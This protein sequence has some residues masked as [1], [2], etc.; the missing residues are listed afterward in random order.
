MLTLYINGI[1]AELGQSVAL[2]LTKTFENLSNPTDY[3]SEY[4]KTIELPI[5]ATNNKIFKHFYMADSMVTDQT[6]DPRKK[7]P[8]K[9]LWNSEVVMSGDAKLENANT[10][11][12]DNKYEITLY[13]TFGM[14]MNELSQ[15][16]F[17]PYEDVDEKYVI[18]TPFN[19]D[20]LTVD[21]FLVKESFEQEEH[22]MDGEDVLDYIGFIPTYQG[23]YTDFQS[24]KVRMMDIESS[25][26]VTELSKERDEHY[27]REFRS[28]YQQP[29]IWVNKMWNMLQNKCAE[30]TDYN[31]VLHPSWFNMSNPYW[32][33]L[34][35][36]CPS[37]YNGDDNYIEYSATI[38]SGNT[39][40]RKQITTKNG[41]IQHSRMQV[42]PQ[43][44]S[45]D[46]VTYDQ[47][48][49]VFNPT[50][51]IG[52]SAITAKMYMVIGC[53]DNSVQ[54]NLH[55]HYCRIK[56]GNPVYVKYIAVD[57]ETNQP[58]D[59][60]SYTY[61]FYSGNH[62]GFTN[63]DESVDVG[64]TNRDNPDSPSMVGVRKLD[65]WWW[66]RNLDLTL[67]VLTNKPYRLEVEVY[68]NI[69]DTPFEKA[70]SNIV[71]QWDIL[72]SDVWTNGFEFGTLMKYGSVSSIEH[73]R[74]YS[75]ISMYRIFPKDMTLL[76]VL[77]NYS[78]MFGLL[79]DV[80]DDNKTITVKTRNA[81][82]QNKVI[83]DWTD[84]V[85]K[86][87]D[88]KMNPITF[89]TKY[90]YFNVEDGDCTRLKQYQDK[91]KYGYGSKKIDTEYDFNAE[92]KDLFSGI[93]PSIVSQK[94]QDSF[95]INTEHPDSANFMGYN[96]KVYPNE[97]YVDNDDNGDN[98]GMSGAFYFRRG[99]FA[100]DGRIS[101]T[102]NN[103]NSVVRIT[104]D[105]KKMLLADEYCWNFM[106]Q[107]NVLC[108][109]LPRVTTTLDG[110]SIHFEK[111][112]EYYYKNNERNTRFIY[113]MYWKDF[114]D[115][116]YSVQNKKVECF[117]Y[118]TPMEYKEFTFYKFITINN[119][120]YHINK[121]TDYDF[122][123]NTPTKVELVQVWDLSKYTNGQ[124][125]F[126]YLFTNQEI[127]VTTT[128]TPYNVESSSEWSVVNKPV[129]MD[130]VRNGNKLYV[131]AYNTPIR[132]RFGNVLLQNSEGDTF[133]IQVSQDPSTPILCDDRSIL[134]E[135]GGGTYDLTVYHT[136]PVT[137][138]NTANWLT[139]T[140]GR[141]EGFY[142][143]YRVICQP[144]N[145]ITTRTATI[146]L[147]TSQG[148][149][150]VAVS[151]LANERIVIGG[152]DDIFILDEGD[153][154]F[155]LGLNRDTA[156]GGYS[157]SGGTISS[158]LRIGRG[159]AVINAENSGV[160]TITAKDGST[161][162]IPYIV[163]Q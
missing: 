125:N 100:P 41:L 102:A 1:E 48:T 138:Q 66:G 132:G 88:F 28:Y 129:W 45:G 91:Y 12:N 2:N 31:I 156:N 86:S 115:E 96:Y 145:R 98:A 42:K 47:M 127:K 5:T 4:S 3:Y 32:K 79:W 16:T 29:F 18:D 153:N 76:S 59:G 94:G 77:L 140:T 8:F 19:T 139:V 13:S 72:W 21:R 111:P 90:V 58:I 6:I 120:L 155:D 78:K 148:F 7:Q 38:E 87:K 22:N 119:V 149:I 97:V 83:E 65:G 123:V 133:I 63:F 118:I 39:Y 51:R 57:N 105:S 27:M 37:L 128:D 9:L 34:I 81:Y 163:R 161:T 117:M 112:A 85:D 113:E 74:S 54:S 157:I 135:K 44:V 10:I 84:K 147:N 53:L 124:R 162:V 158:D 52:F 80:D 150:D 151:Q 103:G 40:H 136:I 24:D 82:F 46:N 92:S 70:F 20:N 67:K 36:T 93:V 11:L 25:I 61:M 106:E 99:T 137:V 159:T 43:M 89:D 73:L 114:I 33:D 134:F 107:Y 56:N 26:A 15:C 141:N 23:Q 152:D 101:G 143:T 130:A 49:G 109:A 75:D 142:Q 64:T 68:T 160:L 126:H 71:P 69:N 116:R 60:A 144:N 30:L 35:Y 154:T 122:D 121:I 17:N 108:N 131:V 104:D 146:R 62:I 14:V 55:N 95:Y 110:M 50:K